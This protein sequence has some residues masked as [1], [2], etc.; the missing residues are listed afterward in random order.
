MAKKRASIGT[1]LDTALA[2][3]AAAKNEPENQG[4]P[5]QSEHTQSAVSL[6]R[7]DW[8][9]LRKLAAARVD[10]AG[11]GKPS[12]SEIIRELIEANRTRLE[13]ELQELEQ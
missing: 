12:M 6:P 4:R 8:R 10:K 9:L 13:A 7:S 2:T 3:A 1:G 5:D 11:R